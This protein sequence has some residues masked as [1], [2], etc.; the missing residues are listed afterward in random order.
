MA[1]RKMKVNHRIVV[2]EPQSRRDDAAGGSQGVGRSHAD[3]SAVHRR[4][5][6]R[7]RRTGKAEGDMN[8][9]PLVFH[10]VPVGGPLLGH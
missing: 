6:R 9:I 1:G 5:M 8:R 2:H 3:A 10:V 4:H 7:V